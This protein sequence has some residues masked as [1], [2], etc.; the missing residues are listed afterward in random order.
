MS[1]GSY[2]QVPAMMIAEGT[3]AKE[4]KDILQRLAI[5]TM[6]D[7]YREHTSYWQSWREGEELRGSGVEKGSSQKKDE[8]NVGVSARRN[9]RPVLALLARWMNYSYCKHQQTQDLVPP[10][11]FSLTFTAGLSIEY[12]FTIRATPSMPEATPFHLTA[13]DHQLLAMTDEEYVPH[14]WADL[15]DIIGECS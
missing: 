11:C 8:A 14:D 1:S 3:R 13:L 9:L 7:L 6:A 5:A 2:A 15:R 10:I 12:I 4:A